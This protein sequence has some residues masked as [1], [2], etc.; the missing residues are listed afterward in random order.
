MTMPTTTITHMEMTRR[1][2]RQRTMGKR[3][4]L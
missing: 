2:V 3:G 1:A 4:M